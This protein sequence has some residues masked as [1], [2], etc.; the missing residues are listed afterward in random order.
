[1]PSH[2]YLLISIWIISVTWLLFSDIWNEWA[3]PDLKYIIFMFQSQ[4]SIYKRYEIPMYFATLLFT[5]YKIIFKMDHTILKNN[6]QLASL[7]R[8]GVRFPPPLV[9]IWFISYIYKY[10]KY[11]FFERRMDLLTL[12]VYMINYVDT[13]GGVG[14][15]G[16]GGEGGR[17]GWVTRVCYQM[18]ILLQKISIA[19]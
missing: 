11:L 13:K 17:G 6:C 19:L 1:M 2:A 5:L 16:W 10:K 7:G 3:E 14:G 9:T 12:Y 18:R 8:H 15:G 4:Q